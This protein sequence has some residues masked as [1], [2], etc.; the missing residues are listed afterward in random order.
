MGEPYTVTALI[1]I[2]LGGFGSIGG[3]LAGGLL[4][5]VVEALRHALHQPLAEDAAVVRGVHRR[6]AAGGPN[7][8]FAKR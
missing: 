3:A 8:L 1:V 6:A 4:L 2:T 7:G 5:G